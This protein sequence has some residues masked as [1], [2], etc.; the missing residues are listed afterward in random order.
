MPWIN[1]LF[2]AALPFSFSMNKIR[3]DGGLLELFSN[4]FNDLNDLKLFNF[5]QE[6][7]LLS[8]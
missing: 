1:S 3:I 5:S 2:L 7:T 8:K 6:K 4:A